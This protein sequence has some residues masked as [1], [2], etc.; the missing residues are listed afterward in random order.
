MYVIRGIA[1]KVEHRIDL[2]LEK[3]GNNEGDWILRESGLP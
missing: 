1:A 3:S 2:S